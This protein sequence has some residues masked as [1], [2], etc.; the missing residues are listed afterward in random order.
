MIPFIWCMRRAGNCND[1]SS[2]FHRVIIHRALAP[3]GAAACLLDIRTSVAFKWQEG[4]LCS[5]P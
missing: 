5:K 2:C 4:S 1:L 3:A